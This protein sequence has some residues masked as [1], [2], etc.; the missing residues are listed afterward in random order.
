MRPFFG[1]STTMT[2]L[3]L[4]ALLVAAT[5]VLT[6]T[7]CRPAEGFD[8]YRGV[9]L[10]ES[11]DFDATDETGTA[12]WQTDASNTYMTW[13]EAGSVTPPGGV[14]G[15]VY[16]LEANNLLSN[17]DFET[18]DIS[19]WTPTGTAST[20][21]NGSGFNSTQ[22]LSI[23]QPQGTR[24]DIDLAAGMADGLVVDAR[25]GVLFDFLNGSNSFL[26]ELND[27]TGTAPEDYFRVIGSS[28][29]QVAEFPGP[30]SFIQNGASGNAIIRTSTAFDT[31]SIGG[32][33]E[34]TGAQSFIDGQIDNLRVVRTDVSQF[35]RLP[36]PFD[37]PSRD[38]LIAGGVYTLSV[39][40]RRDP[41][42]GSGN[43]F[44][45]DRV[46]IGISTGPAGDVAT[47]YAD[48][49]DTSTVDAS[50]TQLSSEFSGPTFFEP[51]DPETI[52]FYLLIAPNAA[53]GSSG[54]GQVRT[55]AGSILL[56]GPTLSWSPN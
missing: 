56:S 15:P 43:R 10:I 12:L 21:V 22:T 36:V 5:A 3:R 26:L 25:Y 30:T 20:T 40:V 34:V 32:F 29:G 52:I 35:V 1:T 8:E 19:I 51:D 38:H 9:N 48:V 11:R 53:Q 55:D 2:S 18:A 50:W 49:H 16:R 17:G 28:P 46:S 54:D 45:A 7:G 4:G 23:Q 41:T 47:P 31:L 6:I 44:H 14:S 27:G 13:E 39:W 24:I 33:T 42:S 37:E